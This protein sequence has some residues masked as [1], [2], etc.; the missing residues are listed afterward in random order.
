MPREV[1]PRVYLIGRTE[2]NDEEMSKWLDSIGVD[3][4]FVLPQAFVDEPSALVAMAAKRCYMS[5]QPGLNR[6]VTKIREDYGE[7]LENILKSGHGSVLEHA[8]FNLAIEGVSRVF[9][10]EMNRHRA[11]WA[12]SEGS[13]RYIRFDEIPYWVPTSWKGPDVVN[14]VLVE[15]FNDASYDDIEAVMSD[16]L[17]TD[18]AST[19]PPTLNTLDERKHAS[20]L[21][22]RRV[23]EDAERAYSVLEKIWDMDAGDKDFSYKKLITSAMRRVIPMGV[24]TGGVWTGN[25]RA[26]RHVFTMRCSPVAEE[27]ILLVF[28]S[29]VERLSREYPNVFGDFERDEDG[30]WRPRYMHV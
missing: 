17:T 14:S 10:A 27:E 4:A 2:T 22:M 28:S 1:E 20:R 11:G 7:Y 9:T 21:I 13:M 18:G 23:F 25:V 12:I 30:F 24:A 15:L 29:V 5:F 19:L 8:T 16:Q 3:L 6:N 26:L